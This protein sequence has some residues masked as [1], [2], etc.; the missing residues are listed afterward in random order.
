[1]FSRRDLN[2]GEA[3]QLLIHK[4]RKWMGKSAH[5]FLRLETQ[6]GNPGL[7][8]VLCIDLVAAERYRYVTPPGRNRL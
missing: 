6:C 7:R 8:K 2:E 3:G 1:M 4:L 5:I